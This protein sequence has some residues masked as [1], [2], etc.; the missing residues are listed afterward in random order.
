MPVSRRIFSRRARSAGSSFAGS[1][2]A[3]CVLP[4]DK[5][6]HRRTSRMVPSSAAA[7]TAKGAIHA[8]RSKPWVVGA[9][10]TVAPY[11]AAND[12]RI[13]LS[14]LPAAMAALSSLR[15]RPLSGQPTWLHSPSI[16]AQLQ[17]HISLCPRSLN[18]ELASVAPIEKQMATA[19]AAACTVLIQNEKRLERLT[20]GLPSAPVHWE[21]LSRARAKQQLPGSDWEPAPPA[22]RRPAPP[23]RPR[24]SPPADSGMP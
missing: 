12:A 6:A 2:M 4:T 23:A 22:C 15:I 17:V 5:F 13:S 7:N 19:S 11:L 3:V 14:L 1:G 18:R 9:A 20:D 21:Q 24:S 10:S 16:C 8:T